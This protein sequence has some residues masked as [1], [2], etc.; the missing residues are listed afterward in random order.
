MPDSTSDDVRLLEYIQKYLAIYS[1]R[2]IAIYMG[3]D[4][5]EQ[6]NEGHPHSDCL[7]RSGKIQLCLF[8]EYES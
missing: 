6:Y 2:S 4:E 7:G 1:R 5:W 3:W 8:R